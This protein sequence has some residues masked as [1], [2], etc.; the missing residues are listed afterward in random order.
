MISVGGIYNTLSTSKG[1]SI[2]PSGGEISF[3]DGDTVISF[4]ANSTLTVYE[5]TTIQYFLVGGGGSGAYQMNTYGQDCGG[6]GAG[7]VFSGYTTLS[8]GTYTITI[9]AGG[10]SGTSGGTSSIGS[11]LLAKG[12]NAAGGLKGGNSG[13]GFAGALDSPPGYDNVTYSPYIVAIGG[14]GAGSTQDGIPATS[15]G[16]FSGATGGAGTTTSIRGF[17]EQF[18]GGGGGANIDTRPGAQRYVGLGVF[19]GGNGYLLDSDT[20]LNATPGRVNSGGGGGASRNS[21]ANGRGGSGIVIIRF[22]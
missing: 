22:N 18:A 14:S 16:D 19:G 20:T 4:S 8:A 15:G 5:P 21:V 9:G 2:F 1:S 3:V 7:E 6:G 11:S 17:S 12:G 10:E 13:N